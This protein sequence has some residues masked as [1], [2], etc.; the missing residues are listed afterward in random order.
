MASAEAPNREMLEHAWRYFALHAGQRMSIF[1]YFLVL[2]SIVAAGLASCIQR[3]G[4]FQ[5]LGAGL[6]A[7]LALVAFT[8]WKLDQRT[9][10]LIKHAENAIAELEH[11]FPIQCSRLISA[12]QEHTKKNLSAASRFKRLW[13]YGRSFRLVFAVMGFVGIVGAAAC[14]YLYIYQPGH[15]LPIDY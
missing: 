3:N 5:L 2:S 15:P 1:N 4:P 12:E 10:F 8:F 9:S 6:G 14:L 13:T 7:L 11:G